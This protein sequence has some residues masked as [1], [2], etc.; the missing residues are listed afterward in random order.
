MPFIACG[1][2]SGTSYFH[3]FRFLRSPA[4]KRKTLRRKVPQK[5]INDYLRLIGMQVA[6]YCR[7]AA[8]QLL[9]S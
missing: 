9:F 2:R 5:A 7:L 3:V 4:Q 8:I 1:D 6:I